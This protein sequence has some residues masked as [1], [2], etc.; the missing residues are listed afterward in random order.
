M[1]AEIFV[2]ADLKDGTS[3]KASRADTNHLEAESY[4]QV[5]VTQS[6]SS[7]LKLTGASGSSLAYLEKLSA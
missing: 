6:L 3:G 2:G 4:S 7:F 1:P 5:T